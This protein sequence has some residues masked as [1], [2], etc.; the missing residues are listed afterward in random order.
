M[1]VPMD[2]PAPETLDAPSGAMDLVKRAAKDGAADAQA[3]ADRVLSAAG[4]FVCRFVYTT[5]YT[6]SYGVVFPST[7][8]SRA[9]PRDN[10]AVR[11]L[12]DGA[13]A[14][15]RKVDELRGLPETSM[16]SGPIV[17]ASAGLSG[18]ERARADAG[19]SP[20]TILPRQS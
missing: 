2:V 14:A 1:T 10:V 12:I 9:V 18:A 4:L 3:A 19:W 11:G 13:A 5:C 15:V 8:I 6:V 7:M 20:P 17:A 16:S